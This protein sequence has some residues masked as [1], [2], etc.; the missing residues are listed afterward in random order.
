MW[1]EKRK[2]G[3][4]L[5]GKEEER[6]HQSKNGD[7]GQKMNRSSKARMCESMTEDCAEV[8]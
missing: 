1:H 4:E 6:I 7:A 5:L 2:K 3:R 8:Q